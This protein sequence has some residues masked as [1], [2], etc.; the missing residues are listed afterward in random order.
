ML[1]FKYL[2][3]ETRGGT[4]DLCKTLGKEEIQNLF[5]DYLYSFYHFSS[6][7]VLHVQMIK[8]NKEWKCFF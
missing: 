1:C 8:L 3:A 4:S 6:S 7:L 5:T 2:Q